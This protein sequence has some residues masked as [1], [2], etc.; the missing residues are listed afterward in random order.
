MKRLLSLKLV[1]IIICSVML[2]STI[3]LSIRAKAYVNGG[4]KIGLALYQK[5]NYDAANKQFKKYAKYASESCIKNMSNKMKEAYLKQLLMYKTFSDVSNDMQN[6][7]YILD[8]YLTDV[9]KDGK[10][11]LL[12]YSR[13]CASNNMITIYKY[14]DYEAIKVKSISGFHSVLYAYPDDNGF[15]RFT[16]YN[17]NETISLITL[18]GNKVVEKKI[19]SRNIGNNDSYMYLPYMLASH[20]T[21]DGLRINYSDLKSDLDLSIVNLD[22]SEWAWEQGSID[23]STGLEIDSLKCIRTGFIKY[24]N[25]ML[26]I[27]PNTGY[28]YIVFQYAKDKK[29]YICTSWINTEKKI[30]IQGAYLRFIIA[31]SDD[32]CVYPSDCNKI[33]FIADYSSNENLFKDEIKTTVESVKTL[34]SYSNPMLTLCIFTDLH[35]PQTFNSPFDKM[36]ANIKAIN[37]C[38]HFDGL[39]SLGDN[40]DGFGSTYEAKNNLKYVKARMSFITN[41]NFSLMGN[42]DWNALA[43]YIS[44]KIYSENEIL[45]NDEMHT[46]LLENSPYSGVNPNRSTDFYVDYPK[47][48]IRVVCLSLGYVDYQ[49]V[50]A[51]WLSNTALNTNKSVLIL[52]HCATKSEWGYKNDISNGFLIEN[53]LKT[54]IAKGGEVIGYING[55]THGDMIATSSDLP[56]SEISIGCA[57]FEMLNSGTVGVTYQKREYNTVTEVLFDVVCIDSKNKKLHFIRFGAGT[58][59]TIQYGK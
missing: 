7:P 47:Y 50:T 10:A 43:H 55:H 52:S 48:N 45:S 19:G 11:E 4:I 38:L 3:N 22:L 30:E 24:K 42:H 33:K 6:T 49:Q 37:K 28:R 31:K 58:D 57:K 35:Y 26:K 32:A 44:P 41:K 56:F 16:S 51:D 14:T 25:N 59:R 21:K 27:I 15:I 9:D 23:S 29:S 18:H 54:F 40:I 39:Y 13:K 36:F 46:L 17:G 5:G 1:L 2:I 12:V 34:E 20:K 53:A 8:Y